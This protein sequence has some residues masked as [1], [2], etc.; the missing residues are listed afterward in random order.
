MCWVVHQ[1][2]GNQDVWP[3]SKSC[4]IA[5]LPASAGSPVRPRR[6][7]RRCVERTRPKLWPFSLPQAVFARRRVATIQNHNFSS[8]RVSRLWIHTSRGMAFRGPKLPEWL[9][10]RQMH[11]S[12]THGFRGVISRSPGIQTMVIRWL[13]ISSTCGCRYL[14]VSIWRMLGG[15]WLIDY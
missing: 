9:R 7:P 5:S 2:S 4:R 15:W 12:T 6:S 3:K 10:W 13:W 14:R 1:P 11:G 8:I